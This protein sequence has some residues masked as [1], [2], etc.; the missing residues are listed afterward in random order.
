MKEY[1]YI[2]SNKDWQYE[3]KY[4]FGASLSAIIK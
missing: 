3:N 4:K 2:L 1:I